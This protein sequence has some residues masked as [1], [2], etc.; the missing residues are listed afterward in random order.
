VAAY[1]VTVIFKLIKMPL[2]NTRNYALWLQYSGGAQ[3]SGLSPQAQKNKGDF[4]TT[5]VIDVIS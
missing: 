1:A 2:F 5:P 3:R 4:R